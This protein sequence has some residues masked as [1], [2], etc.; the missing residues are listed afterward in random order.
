MCDG[1]ADTSLRPRLRS[2][3]R[4]RARALR[5]L[6]LAWCAEQDGLGRRARERWLRG[7]ELPVPCECASPWLAI[8]VRPGSCHFRPIC[9]SDA[10]GDA[11]ATWGTLHGRGGG[12]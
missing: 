5:L 12:D 3:D 10:G 1:I 4:D 6:E 11:S 9:S 7:L 8:G 2:G